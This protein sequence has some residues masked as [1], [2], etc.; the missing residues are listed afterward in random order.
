[1]TLQLAIINTIQVLIRLEKKYS[2][3]KVYSLSEAKKEERNILIKSESQKTT[4]PNEI[5]LKVIKL[6]ADV[7]DNHLLTNFMNR[8]LEYSCF[9]E[10]A[11]NY[12]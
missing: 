11:K 9:S 12:C 1:M 10:N 8:D 4:G 2:N 5:P 6:S 3:R 7:I